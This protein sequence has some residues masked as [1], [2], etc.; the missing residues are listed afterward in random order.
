MASAAYER[1]KTWSTDRARASL[2]AHNR[3]R[4]TRRK[5]T[6]NFIK[7]TQ[8]APS[9]MTSTVL[10]RAWKSYEEKC[11]DVADVLKFLILKDK[12]EEEKWSK[13]LVALGEELNGL[14]LATFSVLA[15]APKQEEPAPDTKPQTTPH[16]RIR[17]DLRPDV[18]SFDAT[19]VEFKRCQSRR[20]H[21]KIQEEW[22]EM[23]RPLV[24]D[25]LDV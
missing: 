12:P 18:L 17:H 21:E 11:T 10:R 1:M 2:V 13:E 3:W 4:E 20:E 7:E 6:E 16:I 15:T 8:K 9:T 19:H 22:E 24:E 23:A 5:D 14:K 25:L